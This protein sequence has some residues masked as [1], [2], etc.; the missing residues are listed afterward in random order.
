MTAAPAPGKY[1]ETFHEP[2]AGCEG[3]LEGKRQRSDA[4]PLI[5]CLPPA[6]AQEQLQNQVEKGLKGVNI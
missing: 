6:P 2:G 3:N 1:L 5:L 4:V